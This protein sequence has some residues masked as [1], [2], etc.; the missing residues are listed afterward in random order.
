M[1]HFGS[2]APTAQ[3]VL[4]V[5]VILAEAVNKQAALHGPEKLALV[6]AALRETL[7]IPDI[8]ARIP[9]EVFVA[10]QELI[11]HVVPE[12]ITLVVEAGRGGFALKKPSVG[13]VAGLAALFCRAG[14]AVA[15]AA[16]A[17]VAVAEVATAVSEIATVLETQ[18]ETQQTQTQQ[19]QNPSDTA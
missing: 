16:K 12:T 7:E 11:D 13:C 10:L 2:S 6:V 17:P 8:K 19:T 3:T 18:T 4:R 15:V 5:S 9:A 14:A 1:R